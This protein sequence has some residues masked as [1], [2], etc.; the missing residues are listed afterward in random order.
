MS[1]ATYLQQGESI[2]FPNSTNDV[3]EA[4]TIQVVG[5]RIGVIGCDIKP[6]EV[7]SVHM[8]GTYLMPL[9]DSTA[10]AIGTQLYWDG[11]GITATAGTNTKAGFAAAAAEAGADE[12]LVRINA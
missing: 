10:V 9:S 4:N 2:D 3:I 11:D 12:I 5:D 1:K 8:V 6:G 7:G